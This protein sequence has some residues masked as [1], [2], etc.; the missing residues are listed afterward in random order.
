VG[1]HRPAAAPRSSSRPARHRG[2]ARHGSASAP[3]CYHAQD[4]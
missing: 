3:V 1:R 4:V 2:R